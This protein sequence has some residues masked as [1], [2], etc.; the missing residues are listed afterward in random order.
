MEWPVVKFLITV[1]TTRFDSLITAVDSSGFLANH[2][3][4]VQRADG[5]ESQ[6]FTC[7]Q[8]IDDIDR[9]YAEADIII[10]HAGA[11]SVF[12]L[13]EAGCRIIVVPNLERKDEH[14]LELARYVDEQGYGLLCPLPGELDSCLAKLTSFEPVAYEK[15]AFHAG[16]EI[17]QWIEALS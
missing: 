15:Q 12:R 7:T 9:A 5:I 13:L 4:L 6:R 11:G 16:P 17:V 2:E 14:Q 10:T 8:F 1:G 3:V